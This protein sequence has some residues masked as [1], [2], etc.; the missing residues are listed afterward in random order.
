MAGERGWQRENCRVANPSIVS[1]LE[2]VSQPDETLAIDGH[3]IHPTRGLGTLAL[4]IDLRRV[5]QSGL[6]GGSDAGSGV[7]ETTDGAP[8]DF[9][10]DQHRP[11]THDEI[12]L[13]ALAAEIPFHELQPLPEQ[14]VEC[15]LL[16]GVA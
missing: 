4:Q 11:F 9:H 13:A 7:A 1:S 10:E 15:A 12:D 14:M 3:D 6:L 2:G 8:P 5:Q 16:A